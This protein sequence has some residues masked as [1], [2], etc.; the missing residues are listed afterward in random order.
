MPRDAFI[1]IAGITGESP[2]GYI[3]I[4][5]FS[6]GASNPSTVGSSAGGSSAG[7]VSLSD[8]SITKQLDG[9]SPQLFQK[10]VTGATIP[11]VTLLIKSVESATGEEVTI[12]FT[13]VLISMYK[14]DET[15]GIQTPNSPCPPN[16]SGRPVESISFNFRELSFQNVP[17]TT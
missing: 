14:L 5:S 11:N 8:F 12:T 16:Q 13:D 10:V 1:K 4:F 2:E 15:P 17:P 3:E 9:S 6:F 7:K